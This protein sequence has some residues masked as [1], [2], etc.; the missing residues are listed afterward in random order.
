VK[1]RAFV[2]AEKTSLDLLEEENL[3]LCDLFEQLDGH[4]GSSIEDRYD[5]GNLAKLI[6][7]HI[8]IR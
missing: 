8:A 4:R 6:I 2:N 5:H 7:R 3:L 1:Q